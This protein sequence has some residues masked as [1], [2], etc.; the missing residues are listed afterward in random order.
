MARLSSL[1]QCLR[2]RPGAYP[3]VEHLTVA[4][5]GQALT[6][7]TNSILGWKGL[8]G[9]NPLVYYDNLLITTVKV[10]QYGPRLILRPRSVTKETGF[11][12]FD[13]RGWFIIDLVAAIPFDLLLFG[14]DTDEVRNFPSLKFTF[15]YKLFH[16]N[17]RTQS[18]PDQPSL[19]QSSLVQSSLAQP[20]KAQKTLVKPR[21]YPRKP[22]Q[23]LESSLENPSKA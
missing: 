9:I 20:S 21:I 6:L 14:S 7:P 13:N 23:S 17:Q 15:L 1:V 4:S 22:E 19:A 12:N 18:S 2:I 11:C 3:R 10:L 8:P 5:L 16:E